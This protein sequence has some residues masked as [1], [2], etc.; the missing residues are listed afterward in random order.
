MTKNNDSNFKLIKLIIKLLPIIINFK[1]DRKEWVKRERKNIDE[2]K[3]KKN[4][5][6][7]LKIFIQLGPSYIKLGQWLSSRSDILP[8]PYLEVFATLQDDV[9]VEPFE[10]VKKIIYKELGNL[11]E[12]F[13]YFN[14]D[15]FSGAS[16]GQV[17]HAKYK[18]KDVVVKISRP[19]IEKI[20]DEDI[21]IIKKLIPLGTR[22]ID[23]NLRF[24]V[25]GMF[26]QFTETIYEEMNYLKE[27]ENLLTIKKIYPM[28]KKL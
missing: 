5:Q 20:V 27:A 16:L 17:Y 9:P 15:A 7:A 12:N 13:D 1:R 4:A 25:E 6:K 19:G 21:S 24:S 2:K 22:F 28:R 11:E 3:Y 18:G 14:K 23:P 8:Q 10:K 26:S